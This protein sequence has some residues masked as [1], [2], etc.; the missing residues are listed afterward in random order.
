MIQIHVFMQEHLF[1]SEPGVEKTL[2]AAR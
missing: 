2:P 1:S